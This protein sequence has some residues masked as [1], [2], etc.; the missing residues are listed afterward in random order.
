MKQEIH[1]LNNFASLCHITK[2]KTLSKN[3]TKY[4]TWTLVSSPFVS[5]QSLAQPLLEIEIYE[6]T[7]LY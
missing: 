4:T 3:S 5:I 6:T 2:E 1:L 7:S